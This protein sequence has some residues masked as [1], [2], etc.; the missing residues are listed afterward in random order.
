[1]RRR[2]EGSVGDAGRHVAGAAGKVDLGH[3]GLPLDAVARQAREVTG[4]ASVAVMALRVGG[5]VVERGEQPVS[6]PEGDGF[7]ERID[8][9][10][11]QRRDPVRVLTG[12][13]S[14]Y[15]I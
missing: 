12:R 13:S 6:L 11:R 5:V 4:D 8:D 2:R 14:S 1:M 3:A 10:L 7:Q 9:T 15:A